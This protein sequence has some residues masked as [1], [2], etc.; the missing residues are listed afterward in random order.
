[1]D[2]WEWWPFGR[3]VGM[4]NQRTLTMEEGVRVRERGG[5]GMERDGEG[6]GRVGEREGGWWPSFWT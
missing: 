5:V 1:M 3:S 6:D 2:A 4:K